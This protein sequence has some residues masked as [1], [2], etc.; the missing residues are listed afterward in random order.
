MLLNYLAFKEFCFHPEMTV[1]EFTAKRLAPLYGAERAADLW[2]IIDDVSGL[3]KDK[4]AAAVR[5]ALPVAE[6][7]AAAA[8]SYAQDNW[9]K[10]RDF[11]AAAVR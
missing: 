6:S 10:L 11:L 9:R 4:S 1:G 7:A 8:P 3:P 5:A 2:K